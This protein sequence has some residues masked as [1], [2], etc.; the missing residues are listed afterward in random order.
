MSTFE[1]NGRFQKYTYTITGSP[2]SEPVKERNG[3]EP[4][5]KR[6]RIIQKDEPD[7]MIEVEMETD[8]EVEMETDIEAEPDQYDQEYQKYIK[9]LSMSEQMALKA[10][11]CEIDQYMR[12]NIKPLKYQILTSSAPMPVK[13]QMMDKLKKLSVYEKSS[14]DYGYEWATLQQLLKIPWGKTVRLPISK[15]DGPQRI[16]SY[17]AEAKNFLDSVTYGQHNA[18]SKL[19]LEISR[20]LE[21]PDGGG[22][23]LGIKG[24]PGSGKTT[25]ISKGLSRILN[26]PFSRIDLG[27]A[28]HSDCLFGSRKVFDRSDVGDLVKIVCEAGCMNPVIFFDELDKISISEYGHELVNALNDL[29]DLTRNCSIVDQYLGVPIDLSKA[30]IVFAYNSSD[31]I[32]ETLRSRIHEIEVEAYTDYDKYLMSQSFL[33][34]KACQKINMDLN[35]V[36]F[37]EEGIYE[38]IRHHTRG[39]EGVRE[40]ERK[41]EEIILKLNW[42]RLT[43]TSEE[44]DPNLC[45]YHFHSEIK[46]SF[47][48]SITKKL[49]TQILK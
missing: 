18:K 13:L 39:E 35:T 21:N 38:I 44:T 28:K 16:H 26:R 27:G 6:L 14:G 33:I 22:F 47:P 11:E 45:Q 48:C 15:N 8:I 24:P 42:I 10:V 43:Y 20:F 34:P 29:T 25:L 3:D 30:V 46:A 5:S 4:W 37:T 1:N 12:E 32:Q 41:L 17:L 36:K 2:T 31:C 9:S 40:L 7:P 19:L 23:I 49:V